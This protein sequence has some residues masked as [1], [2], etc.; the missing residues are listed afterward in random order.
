MIRTLTLRYFRKHEDFH[1]DFAT[2]LN[3]LR[4]ANESGKSTVIEAVLYALYGAKV[5][6]DSLAETVTWGHKDSELKVVCTIVVS[7]HD[8]V[9]SRSKTGA[10]CIY[11]DGNEGN[12]RVVGQTEVTNF[13]AEL[14]GAD[15]RTAGLLMLSSQSGLRGTIDD[16]PT[17]VSGLMS[18]LANFDLIDTILARAEARLPTG[19]T[20]QLDTRIEEANVAIKA[21][22]DAVPDITEIDDLN[23]MRAD[24]TE[25]MAAQKLLIENELEPATVSAELDYG[26][27]DALKTRRE[28]LLTDIANIVAQS[29]TVKDRQEEARQVASTRP[30]QALVDAEAR[31]AQE[32]AQGPLLAAYQTF[33]ALPMYPV[34]HWDNTV[35]DFTAS[36]DQMR[37]DEQ[38][39]GNMV[40]NAL[41]TAKAIR[42]RRI[43]DGKCPTCGHATHDD[44]HVKKHND[45]LEVEAAQHDLVVKTASEESRL[46]TNNLKLMAD[47]TKAAAPFNVLAT[48][49]STDPSL[50]IKVD[51]SV[52][53][54]RLSWMGP[55]PQVADIAATKREVERLKGLDHA[56]TSAAGR[57]QVLEEQLAA[58]N[59]QHAKLTEEVATI[60]VPDLDALDA[61]YRVCSGKLADARLCVL[62]LEG[63]IKTIDGTI[64]R[65][66]HEHQLAVQRV[67]TLK[68]LLEQMHA[69]LH[70]L[71]RNNALVTKLKK[72]KPSITDHLWNQVLAAVSN[73]FSTLRG[74]KSV[75]TKRTTGF[76]VNGK[77]VESL[78]GSTIDVLALAVRVALTK[79]FIPHASF[80]V[81]DE[82]AHGCD[83]ARTANVLGFLSSVG[84]SQ[85]LLASH[86]EISESVADNVIALGV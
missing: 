69:D 78:S 16:G 86:D 13:A 63:R 81:L 23:V 6:R 21:A 50:P 39:F 4:G 26:D 65:I 66:N 56:A 45:A 14:L 48:R 76:E 32:H 51:D 20:V 58:L 37:A 74:E 29:N 68:N 70:T 52:Y 2:G 33:R 67:H 84:F 62:D 75:V 73:F 12:L 64:A 77:G 19:N 55:T 30:G 47:V 85:T 57:L 72:L 38:K 27:A 60:V 8:Y 10:E 53:P 25:K 44:E 42:A 71:K 11:S 24:L 80:M 3:V 83:I 1:V 49:A 43:T 28:R 61:K 15:A 41:H 17:A 18:K 9:F 35:D 22:E 34:I 7:G 59:Q 79:T 5:L 31:L 36:R 46:I 82:P 54:P 40:S